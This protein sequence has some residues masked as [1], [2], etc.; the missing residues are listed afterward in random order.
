MLSAQGDR[1][2]WGW[3]ASLWV[4]SLDEDGSGLH[5]HSLSQQHRLP[6]QHTCFSRC[7]EFLIF[8]GVQ[9]QLDTHDTTAVVRLKDG[10]IVAQ[11]G[12]RDADWH[13]RSGVP[14]LTPA[15]PQHWMPG[16][17]GGWT[18]ITNTRTNTVEMVIRGG[19][20]QRLAHRRWGS[21]EVI[22][23]GTNARRAVFY[24]PSPEP[25]LSPQQNPQKR[26]SRS[27][28][29]GDTAS[30]CTQWHHVIFRTRPQHSAASA[31]HPETA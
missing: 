27:H 1:L 29:H 12:H 14:P 16:R 2:L 19:S 8:N 21:Q 20:N 10:Q 7:G 31:R 6:G 3:D 22:A 28:H 13:Q 4:W 11:F 9:D 30:R 18:A 24:K 25:G 26:L 5:A 17:A 23:V 15:A